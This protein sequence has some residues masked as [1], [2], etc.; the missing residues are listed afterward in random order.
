MPS[1]WKMTAEQRQ[2]ISEA[3]K[4]YLQTPAGKRQQRRTVLA[5]LRARKLKAKQG[6]HRNS[7]GNF[8]GSTV[9]SSSG[10]SGIPETTLAYA[11]GHLQSWIETYARSS[12]VSS[13]ALAYRLG[14]LLQ[15]SARR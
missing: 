10:A 13:A 12:G 4:R 14:Q 5:S 11:L 2:R 8:N 3:R 9:G 1:G 7:R 6:G 15:R